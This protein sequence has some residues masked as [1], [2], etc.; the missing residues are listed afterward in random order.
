MRDTFCR[1]LAG[2]GLTARYQSHRLQAVVFTSDSIGRN[3]VTTTTSGNTI[4]YSVP[5]AGGGTNTFSVTTGTVNVNT[6]FGQ[7]DVSEFSNGS[8]TAIQSVTLPDGSVYSFAYDSDSY[9]EMTGMTLPTGGVVSLSYINYE[10]SF[11]NY[12][13]WISTET[14]NDYSTTFT[15]EPLSPANGNNREQMTLSR[16]TGDSRVYT[17]TLNDGAWD[18]QTDTYS[19][20][21]QSSPKIM[22]V[23]NNYNFTA[24]PCPS[25]ESWIC[26][27]GEYIA[28]SSSAVTLD[29]TGQTAQTLY[30]YDAPWSG[31]V[32]SIQE[33]DY[34]VTGTPTRETDYTYNDIGDG[35]FLVSTK[36][37]LFN[38][39]QYSEIA[40]PSYDAVQPTTEVNGLSG[41]AQ[42]TTSYTY[43]NNGMKVS[44]TDPKGNITTYAYKPVVKSLDAR[45][46]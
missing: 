34:G 31:K 37:E 23:V 29:D 18:G 19:G 21:P 17:L 7:S 24:Y 11:N 4:Q 35:A 22:T 45:A 30:T 10:D 13:R 27:G 43:D 16:S 40:Y 15:P 8:L 46:V 3:L 1:P 14:E 38:G 39:N 5:K 44:K 25:T 41:Q 32:N 33:F 26:T 6:N 20:S 42:A 12:N 9:G 36:I 28:A 2:T